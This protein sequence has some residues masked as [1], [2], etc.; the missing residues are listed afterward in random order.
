VTNT[1]WLNVQVSNGNNPPVVQ[2]GFNL[3]ADSWVYAPNHHVGVNG[4]EFGETINAAD[5]HQDKDASW[6]RFLNGNGGNDSIVGGA[7][8]D[9][10]FGNDGDDSLC[11]RA[12]LAA[13][14]PTSNSPPA[15][16]DS[17]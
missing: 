11:F 12:V 14:S 15:R 1:E 7:A 16:Q 5:Y 4:S 3:V 6:T 17:S 2:V 9:Q 10:L 8:G 13:I